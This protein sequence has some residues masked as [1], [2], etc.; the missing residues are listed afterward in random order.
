MFKIGQEVWWVNTF[1][2]WGFTARIWARVVGFTDKRVKIEALLRDGSFKPMTVRP[3]KLR[4]C[5]EYYRK[6]FNDLIS[7]G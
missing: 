3:D 1:G 2:G 5:E 6:A 4:S 7:Y